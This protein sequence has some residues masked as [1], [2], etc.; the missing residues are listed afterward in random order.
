MSVTDIRDI[1]LNGMYCTSTS[2]R[3][4]STKDCQHLIWNA[5]GMRAMCSL[6]LTEKTFKPTGLQMGRDW[7]YRRCKACRER[8]LITGKPGGP[9]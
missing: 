1:D 5:T 3:S 7:Q 4:Y 9:S 6:F 8:A 2:S